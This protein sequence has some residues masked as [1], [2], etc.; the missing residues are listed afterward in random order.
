MSKLALITGGT[1]GIGLSIAKKFAGLGINIALNGKTDNPTNF[2]QSLKS[3]YKV[4]FFYHNANM[5]NFSE[6]EDFYSKTKEKYGKS[7]DI[8]VNNAGIQ[9]VSP[10]EN[11][12]NEKFEEIIKVNLISVFYLT[13]LIIPDMKVKKF[14]RIVNIA[15]AHG[16]VASPF[17][18]AYVAAKHGVVGFGKSVALET[19]QD[20]VYL[21]IVCNYYLLLFLLC[22]VNLYLV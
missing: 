9:Y 10:V 8:L 11:F 7:P 21:K 14:G 3:D 20:V 12:P 15:S 22:C 13:K 6:I 16:L 19:A 18:S 4:D 5:L 17:K 2:I 1:S